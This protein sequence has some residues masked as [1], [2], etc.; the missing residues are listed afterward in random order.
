MFDI[1]R[2]CVNYTDLALG[3]YVTAA[4]AVALGLLCRF[5]PWLVNV[6]IDEKN[7]NK[8]AV[9]N[10]RRKLQMSSTHFIPKIMILSSRFLL[11]WILHVHEQTH[12]N[13]NRIFCYIIVSVRLHRPDS[14][15]SPLT[16]AHIRRRCS[17]SFVVY[18]ATK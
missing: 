4:A 14:P 3:A 11:I 10:K 1:I 5:S 9:P 2:F 16:Y 6:L 18:F 7:N 8:K 15:A 13:A 17:F 12:T